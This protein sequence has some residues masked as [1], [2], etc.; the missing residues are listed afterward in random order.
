VAGVKRGSGYIAAFGWWILVV[1][2]GVG[3]AALMG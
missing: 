3:W 1:L 2:F